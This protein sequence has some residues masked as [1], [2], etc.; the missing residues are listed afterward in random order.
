MK[1]LQLSSNWQCKKR[2][3]ERSLFDDSTHISDWIAASVPGTVHQAL[4]ATNQIPDPFYGRNET[5]VQWIGESDWLYRCTFELAAEFVNEESIELC[6]D[7]LDTFSTVWLNGQQIHTSDN[8]FVPYR[9]QVGSQVQVGENELLILFES[10]LHY[11]KERE[12]IH[13]KRAVW[14]GDASRVYVRKAQ[15][16]YGWDWGPTLLTAGPW[17][18]IRLEAYS[19]RISEMYCPTEIALDLK[20][21]RIQVNTTYEINRTV[22]PADIALHVA[23]Y[24]P[25]GELVDE[26]TLPMTGN[27]AQ[28][29]FELRNLQLWWPLGYGEQPL[30]RIVATLHTPTGAV[31]QYEQ[32]LGL[33]RL[34]LVQQPTS[35]ESGTTFF[36]E[37]NNTPI[38]CGG[39]NWIP[40]DSFLPAIT[41]DRYRAWLQLAADAHMT[42]IRVWGGGVYEDDIFYD[43]CDE[44][45]LLVW[46][47]FMFGCGIYPA[48]EWFQK[49]VVAEAEAN[50]RR[51]RHHPSIALWCGN[52]E[53]YSI[54]QS[55]GSYDSSFTGDFTK[56]AFPAR[57]L[58]ER[59]LPE[60]CA[61]LNPER[62]YWPGSPYAGT[63]VNDERRGDLHAWHIGNGDIPYQDYPK[64]RARFISEF[65]M[66]SFPALPTIASF[67]P[68]EELYPQS[69]TIDHHNKSDGGSRRIAGYILDNI[70]MPADLPGYIYAT[71]FIQAEALSVGIRGWRRHWGHLDEQTGGALL[72]QLDDCWPVIS[73]GIVDYALR[74]KAAYYGVR[75]EL[76]PFV[77][78]LVPTT[79]D[80]A[81]LWA[82]N[83]V[84]TPIDAIVE[85]CTWTL[86][87]TLVAEEHHVVTLLANQGT[88]I[89]H[90]QRVGEHILSTCIQKDGVTIARTALW[91]EPFKYLSLAE[92]EIT[93]E[94]QDAHTLRIQAKR[95]AKGV[96]LSAG[97]GVQ[98]SDNMLDLFPDDPQII[99]VQGLEDAEIQ[100][101]SLKGDH[102]Y[103]T[104]YPKKMIE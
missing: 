39:A 42:M 101:R 102:T 30:Y 85:V 37:V 45:G 93:L 26:H 70:R 27:T 15:Y 89:G 77:V 68:Q 49:N 3:P 23:L 11:G 98:W 10:A 12:I 78:G 31:G 52:N 63:D 6:F 38:Y 95:P 67:A 2:T 99:K 103:T 58:Y 57:V 29:T 73:W 61:R 16:H 34:R 100:I 25:T 79:H 46:Q 56:T 84:M 7:G 104:L 69:H 33:R 65:G 96:W 66:E 5:L 91:P 22:Q 76:A 62:S 20:S 80:H 81:E 75:R 36:F 41:P 17:R 13:G 32:R 60:I 55:L 14:N 24:D 86:D 90:I 8:M 88:E 64:T 97:D 21:A 47:D 59:L 40:A 44:L 9:V 1:Q 50:I 71:Q 92:P 82:V 43:I 51:L 4:L 54:A 35:D 28:H 83:G 87:G 18:P 74:P 94:R 72:W 19:A 53:D 48:Y